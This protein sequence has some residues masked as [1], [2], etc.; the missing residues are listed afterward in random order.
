MIKEY[1]YRV[2]DREV[3]TYNIY[4][5]TN[6]EKENFNEV[7]SKLKEEKRV[8]NFDDIIPYLIKEGYTA[9]EVTPH[10]DTVILF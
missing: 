10:V 5:K 7:I 6:A 8:Y 9:E 2:I 1:I 3:Q 4:I